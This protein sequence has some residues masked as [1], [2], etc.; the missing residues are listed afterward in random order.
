MNNLSKTRVKNETRRNLQDKLLYLDAS[1]F[2]E[3]VVD[4]VAEALVGNTVIVEKT[5]IV[6]VLDG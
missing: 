3:L 4:V 6:V 2:V 1:D 5:V